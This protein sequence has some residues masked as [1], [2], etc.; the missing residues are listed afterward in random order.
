[1]K[2]S[3]IIPH[4]NGSNLLENL[5]ESIPQDKEIQI[6]VVDDKSELYHVNFIENLLTKYNFEFYQNQNLKGPGTC[7]NIGLEKAKGEWILF[8]D[9]D[10]YFVK[11]FYDKLINYFESKSEVIFFSPTSRYLGTKEIANRHLSF[12]KKNEAYLKENNK[13]NE[14]FLRYTYMVP[15]SRMVKKEFLNN[16]NI[17]FD[18]VKISEDVMFATKVGHFMKKFEVSNEVIYC[19]I[20][21]RGSFSKILI[22]EDIFDILIDMKISYIKFLDTNLSKGEFDKIMKPYIY[23][24]AAEVLLRS[25]KNFGIKKCFQVF[26]LY[27]RENIRWF[28]LIYLNPFKIMKYIFIVCYKKINDHL[29]NIN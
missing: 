9:S 17:K 21:R 16:H 1:M 26:N 14:F 27:K 4:Y 28:R 2:L 24:K 10:D 25:I 8:A 6:I 11:N 20:Q 7:R 18:E 19:I 5:L 23:N 22:K 13:K 29:K 15:W 3:I 12:K